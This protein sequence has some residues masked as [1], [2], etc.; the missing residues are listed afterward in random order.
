MIHMP[1]DCDL[2]VTVSHLIP[3]EG[4]LVGTFDADS[5]KDTVYAFDAS[6]IDHE[7]LA[8]SATG[9]FDLSA[10]GVYDVVPLERPGS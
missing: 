1:A 6:W 3:G 9:L 2:R 8:R 7:G 5:G 4:V 10:V